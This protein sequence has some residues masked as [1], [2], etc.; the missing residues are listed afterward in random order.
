MKTGVSTSWFKGL[1]GKLLFAS[2]LPFVGF[3]IIFTVATVNVNRLT[4]MLSTAHDVIIPNFV[5]IAAMRTSRLKFNVNIRDAFAQMENNQSLVDLAEKDIEHYKKAYANYKK[6]PFIPGE[7]EIHDGSKADIEEVMK[8]MDEVV[9][10]F[11]SKDPEKTKKAYDT[12]EGRLTPLGEKVAKEFTEKVYSLYLDLTEKEKAL[13][14]EVSKE[15]FYYLVFTIGASALIIFSIFLFIASRV[16]N[17][18]MDISGSLT[19]SN[20][21]VNVAVV[22]LKGAGNNLSSA[23]TESAASLQETVASLEE[24]TSMVRLGSNNAKLAAEL[25]TTSKVSAE[26]GANEI[27]NLIKSMNAISASSKK[28]QEITSVIDDIAFQTNLLALNAAVEAARAG[29]QGK[30][31]AVVAE[32][33]RTLAQRSS[34]SAKDISSLIRESSEQIEKGGVFADKSGALLSNIVESIKK[35]SDL[36]N[37]IAAGSQEQASGIEQINTAMTQLDQA[38]QT[39]ASS[40][41]EITNAAEEINNLVV[42][43]IHLNHD[44]T[45]LVSGAKDSQEKKAA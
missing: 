18:I 4:K 35:V 17:S 42:K 34:A 6:N 28:V 25:A 26:N 44:L 2:L 39:N 40:A 37:E 13:S 16:S 33:V 3:A 19:E 45:F 21:R 20:E 15:V 30:G 36:N 22:Q 38:G 10:G 14:S 23:S 11:K 31:F 1:K 8:I 5:E 9:V 24:I 32:A 12:V 41:L 27:Q 29:E 7:S 43:T